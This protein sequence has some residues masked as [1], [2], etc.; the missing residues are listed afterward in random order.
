MS[1]IDHLKRRHSWLE[2]EIASEQ[3]QR[4]PDDARI[5]QLK[6]LKLAVKDRLLLGRVQH[7]ERDRGYRD[8]EG[9]GRGQLSP[10]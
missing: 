7:R 3:A 6:K 9:A 5:G 4:L 1:L 8:R 10:A 2:H